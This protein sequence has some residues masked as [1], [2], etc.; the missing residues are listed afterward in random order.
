MSVT[1]WGGLRALCLLAFAMLAMP[2]FGRGAP[3]WA[4]VVDF[5]EALSGPGVDNPNHA[6]AVSETLAGVTHAGIF[7]HPA[8]PGSRLVHLTFRDV[9]L[10]KVSARERLLLTLS[11]GIREGFSKAENPSADGCAFV[12][13]IDGVEVLRVVQAIQRWRDARVD[14]TRYAGRTVSVTF[15]TDPLQNSSYDWAV[16]GAP[17]IVVEGR[18]AKPKPIPDV[19][20]LRLSALD[21]RPAPQRI[22]SV[23]RN[24]ACTV[25]TGVMD[26]DLDLATAVADEARRAGA[27][28][29]LSG[30]RLVVGEGPDPENHTLVRV[31]DAHGIA[32][33]QFLAF[34]PGVRGGVAV[35]AGDLGGGACIA[36]SPLADAGVG[37]VRLLT[38]TGGLVRTVKPERD[39]APPYTVAVGRFLA[40]SSA[41]IAVASAGPR[42][43]G[44][45]V[46]IYAGNG[47]LLRRMRLPDAAGRGVTLGKAEGAARDRLLVSLPGAGTVLAID[48]ASGRIETRNVV[49]LRA[50]KVAYASAFGSGTLL[51]PTQDAAFSKVLRVPPAGPAEEVDF[52]ATENR[53]WIQW[54]DPKW[55]ARPDGRYVR[56]SVFRH[57]RTDGASPATRNPK[58][59]LDP[60]QCAGAAFLKGF[61]PLLDAYDRDLPA[62]WEPCFT[63]RWMKG[64]FQAW[65]DVV[66]PSTRLP[67]YVMLSRNNR[68]IEYGEFGSSDF[69]SG[70][71]AFGMPDLDNLYLLPL[72]AF[73]RALAPRFRANPEHFVALEPN[74]EHEIAV[75]TD[76]T[77]GDYNPRM[78]E[79]FYRYLQALYGKQ[80]IAARLGARFTR[81]FDAPRNWDR[82]P[83]D[84]Y[85]QDNPFFKEWVAY[86][87]Y[88][89][90]RRVAETFREALLA[91]FPAE[92]IKSHQIP[93]TYA[94]GRLSAFSTITSRFT[95]IDWELNSGAGYGFTRYGVWYNQPHDAL[96]DAHAAGF[97]AMTLGEYQALT[98][99]ETDAV[100]QLRF[101][102]RNGGMSVHCMMWPAAFDKGYNATMDRAAV[103]VL[104]EDAPRTVQTGGVGQVRAF[105]RGDRAFDIACIGTGPQ[106][107]GL[108]K[109]LTEAGRW[110]G[111][112]YTTPFHAHVDVQPVAPRQEGGR[113][114]VGP[115]DGLDSGCQIDVTM[116]VRAVSGGTL[117]FAVVR[118]GVELPGLSQVVRV[119]A[120]ERRVRFALRV[121]LPVNGIRLVVT[122]RRAT[123]QDV[124]A[125]RQEEQTPRL[126][127][128]IL[129]G[130]R[131]RGG[132]TFDVLPEP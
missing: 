99:S 44:G 50:G 74:H 104:E 37:E 109:S 46:A 91:G 94:I 68:P 45:I 26:R 126:S 34:G 77:L 114:V 90:N 36:A 113:L 8:A 89:V 122:P 71:Y 93:D 56:K 15:L 83:W 82:G 12:V 128:G 105:R 39:I 51:V 86:N 22:V 75:E 106:H 65:R 125:T 9:A 57:L 60:A 30:P 121:Q 18:P 31:L 32:E 11:V 96:Q 4:V 63:H 84:S 131:H 107:T 7:Q 130:R 111:T 112:V 6:S 115:L 64:V 127:R 69:Y 41:Q 33:A 52:G 70:T 95:P 25:V 88:V 110:E 76:G 62:L 19:P 10:P 38:R 78:I 20:I 49:A 58:L 47:R 102:E 67:K 66:D 97:D 23:D 61:Q 2:A 27:A 80:G 28:P 5:V 29:V 108:L 59:A 81:A 14:L 85:S 118:G 73:L 101:I 43:G 72:R 40:L 35:N 92:I 98:S 48:A 55:E 117:R 24:A 16:W 13:R 116:R 123:V 100:N 42:T 79:G 124:L 1:G 120:G 132:V 103:D 54:Y 87:R 3:R 53:F 17:R 119:A 21:A 129:A